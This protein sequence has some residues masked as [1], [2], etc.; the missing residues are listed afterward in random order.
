MPKRIP[1]DLVVPHS[2]EEVARILREETFFR[3]FPTQSPGPI[4]WS[5]KPLGGRVN[6][7]AFTVSLYEPAL[8][9]LTRPVVR[10]KLT[11]TPSGTRVHGDVGLHPW[12]TQTFR[13]TIIAA[14]LGALA[15]GVPASTATGLAVSIVGILAFLLITIASI[16]ANVAHADENVD[17]LHEKLETILRGG[18]APPTQESLSEGLVTLETDFDT[19]EQPPVNLTPEGPAG[20]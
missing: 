14:I 20:S 10:A 12:I 1:L 15:A 7:Q 6:S 9:N 5:H 4:R 18:T 17:R 3:P 8:L 2:P 19:L 11:P 13:L 16:G